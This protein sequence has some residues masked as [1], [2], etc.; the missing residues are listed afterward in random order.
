MLR[1]CFGASGAG[2][3]TGLIEEIIKR[4]F[5]NTGNDFLLI[6]PD[7]F[8]MQTQKDVVRMHPS[9]AIMNI[10]VLSFGRL[11]H[12]VLEETSKSSFSVLDDVGKSL[13]LRRVADI[14]GD[15][16]PVI[17]GNMHKPGY[18]DEVKST[19]SEF[20]QYGIGDEALAILEEK[21]SSKAALNSKI[22]D[23][24]LLYGEFLRYIQGKFITTEETLDILCKAIPKSPLLKD[25]VI[26]F[27]GFTGFTP[28][29]YRVIKEL[30]RVSKE[31]CVSLTIGPNENPYAGSFEEQELFM[32]TKKTVRDLEKIEYELCKE[33]GAISQGS[34]DFEAWR[35]IRNDEMSKKAS[36][37]DIFIRDE[38][39]M[40]LKDNPPLAFLEQNLFRY[41]SCKYSKK[42]DSIQ[43]FETQTTE[44]EVRRTM[45]KIRSLVRDEGYAY[46]DIAVVCGGLSSYG[47]LVKRAARKF[48]IP[49]YIDQN[50]GLLLNPFIEYITSAINIVISGYRYEDVFHYMR[51]GM[52]DFS[53]ED[54]DILENYVRALGIKG[55]K[56]WEDR[57]MRRM[58]TKFKRKKSK[59]DDTSELE[60]IEKLDGMRA[61]ISAEL[62]P[63]FDAKGGTAAEITE[64]L[65]KMIEENDCS[66][67][68][69]RYKEKFEKFGD[70][71]KAKEY[72]QVYKKVSDILKQIA[73]LIGDDK[74][75]LKEYKDILNVGF[76]DIEVGTIPQDVDRVIVGDIERTR[77]REIKALFFMG[78][79]DGLIPANTGGG[80]ILS[81]MDRQFLLDLDTGVE[82]AP[83]PRQQMYIQ[84]LYLYM[85]LTKPTD[86]LVLSYSELGTDGKSVRPAYLISKIESLYEG[87][88]VERPEDAP[89]EEQVSCVNDSLDNL[90][91]MMREYSLG[92]LDDKE[93]TELSTLYEIVGKKYEEKS[94]LDK[95]TEAAFKHYEDRP[96]A[97]N[98]ALA[99]YG[100]NLENSVSRLEKFASCC[101]SHFLR[102]GMGLSE[103]KEY[104]FASADLGNVF[105]E[106]LE[107]Y[108]SEIINRHISWRDLPKEESDEILNRAL[109]ESVDAYGETILLS[110][111]RNEFMVE[112]IKRILIRTVDTLKYQISKG[113][114]EP[115]YVEMDF[116]EA[117]K[118]EEIDIT[119]SEY[120]KR[121]IVES[122]KLHG[123]ID[124]VDLYEDSDHV[125]VKVIDFKS[126]G[127]KLSLASL[128]YGL[129]LQLVMYMNVATA[130]S[131]KIYNGKEAVPAAV[132]YYHVDDPM[133]SGSGDLQPDVINK[134]IIKALRTTGLVNGN[135]DI[136]NM[137]DN[138]INGT[139]DVI[140]VGFNKSGDLT[141]AS[142]AVSNEDYSAISK[143]VD[144][145]IREFG[146]SILNGDIKVNPYEMD[147][148]G[149]CKY[150]EY[151]GIC[152]FD[153]KIPGYSRRKLDLDDKE[154]MELIRNES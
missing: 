105:H 58:P 102:Y 56:Q 65:F 57:F 39:V 71:E 80:G 61:A 116:R 91:E 27:D 45:M 135:R 26:V 84:R 46:R 85:N 76:G 142:S 21:S 122:M 94:L 121:G 149:S 19:I 90:A 111:A 24:R 92:I 153:D 118:I 145:K 18:I 100:A 79:N 9:H 10:D 140:P 66:T 49:V 41:N 154:A 35:N 43:I 96:L 78:V 150:C 5:N 128:Y 126:G 75:E 127:K 134:E 44:E 108:T 106:V 37:G 129:Q 68:L 32:L 147:V 51:S 95:L 70:R 30:L 125:Y 101:Y 33:A 143:Y 88:E 115:A 47:N 124:R 130:A 99:L 151:K 97:K 139:S 28:I 55:R 25:S 112:R 69:E 67:K 8:T 22:K 132:L 52:T 152:G 74:L 16:L 81:D 6:V 137:L 11:S 148:K 138:S 54:T 109:T 103:R 98:I 86:R 4:S 12:R 82:L 123:R 117:G 146:K 60:L 141:A 113:N 14:L 36:G 104:D 64:A 34:L 31:V 107:K 48:D 72:D 42:Q 144:K 83:T 63:L 136:I 1:F 131:K 77:L 29:Q 89:F 50:T 7:Q 93:K 62:K 23:L 119:L 13:V 133:I 73:A 20:M 59:E 53:K 40:R 17:G 3:S 15:R 87:I 2:K 120:E 38:K 114:F 110:N